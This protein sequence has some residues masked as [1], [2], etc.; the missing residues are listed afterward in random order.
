MWQA[1]IK[2]REVKWFAKGDQQW[3][4]QHDGTGWKDMDLVWH[5]ALQSSTVQQGRLTVDSCW[6]MFLLSQLQ[7]LGQI[8]G[9]VFFQLSNENRK[10]WSKASFVSTLPAWLYMILYVSHYQFKSIQN[11]NYLKTLNLYRTWVIESS[12]L[13]HLLFL[14]LL[15]PL[16]MVPRAQSSL[17]FLFPI[18]MS[19]LLHTKVGIGIRESQDGTHV[20]WNIWVQCLFLVYPWGSMCIVYCETKVESKAGVFCSQVIMVHPSGYWGRQPSRLCLFTKV[21]SGA[22]GTCAGMDLGSVLQACNIK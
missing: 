12:V 6:D 7:N 5:R 18:Q 3:L 22:L 2:L 1:E 14:A 10:K 11:S 19:A 21:L 15:T 20:P 17:C 13:P 8:A 4:S 9:P 16:L